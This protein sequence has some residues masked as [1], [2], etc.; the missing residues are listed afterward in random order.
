MLNRLVT[1]MT[2][3]GAD[4]R[5]RAHRAVPPGQD[6]SLV[7]VTGGIGLPFS[8]LFP[9]RVIARIWRE[10]GWLLDEITRPA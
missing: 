9:L 5:H 2:G 6:V 10:R 8:V 3:T 7:N 1:G 4:L